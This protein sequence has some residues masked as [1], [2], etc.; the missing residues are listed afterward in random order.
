MVVRRGFL[1]LT[2]TNPTSFPMTYTRPRLKPFSSIRIFISSSSDIDS[3]SVLS[4][5]TATAFFF[6][7]VCFR[8]PFSVFFD[9]ALHG[10]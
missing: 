5:T 10:A 4:N 3:L 7:L 2:L 9:D 8:Y 6:L 1:Y